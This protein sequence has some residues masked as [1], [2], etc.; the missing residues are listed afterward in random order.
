LY[1]AIASSPLEAIPTDILTAYRGFFYILNVQAQRLASEAREPKSA[2]FGRSRW[3][4]RLGHGLLPGKAKAGVTLVMA[5]NEYSHRIWANDAK[6]DG[7]RKTADEA[8]PEVSLD[9]GK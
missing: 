6:Q 8:A 4:A 2:A 3:S 5:N 1:R 9:D 7:V